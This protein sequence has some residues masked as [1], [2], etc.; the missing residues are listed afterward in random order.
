MTMALLNPKLTKTQQREL[1]DD[2]NYLNTAEIQSF[3]K[4]HKIPYA[5]AIETADGNRR[6]TK[7]RDRK[8]VMLKRV[9]HFLQ[10]GVVLQQTCFPAAVVRFEALPDKLAANDRLFYGQYDKSNRAMIGLLK[11]L[12]GGKFEHG[13]I[14]RILARE[15]WASGKAPTFKKFA[16]EWRKARRMHRG[17]NPEW[18]FL[19]DKANKRAAENWK[20]LRTQKAKKVMA[21]LNRIAVQE[22]E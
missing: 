19:S 10:T 20:M 3:C 16:I 6:E 21:I 17:P 5:I 8:G 22:P 14:A 12:T 9:R 15:L 1:L 13:A 18:A 4:K 11:N 7:D 2:L